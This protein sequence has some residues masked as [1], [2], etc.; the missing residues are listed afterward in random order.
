MRKNLAQNVPETQN[1]QCAER[2][3]LQVSKTEKPHQITPHFKL[4][5]GKHS[6]LVTSLLQFL[7]VATCSVPLVH[8]AEHRVGSVPVVSLCGE[9]NMVKPETDTGLDFD[10]CSA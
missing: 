4:V 6:C 5:Q 7:P 10:S 8:A 3:L 9:T 2:V 1:L